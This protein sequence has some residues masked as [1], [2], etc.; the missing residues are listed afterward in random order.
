MSSISH[1]TTMA[2]SLYKSSY[3]AFFVALADV[4]QTY[5]VTNPILAPHARYYV[6][7]MRIKAYQQLLESYRSLTL[8]RMSRSFGVSEAFIDRDLSRFIASGRIACT[9]DKVSGV[10]TTDKLSSQNKTAIYEQFLKQGDLL[11]SG[12]LPRCFAR[13]DGQTCTNSTASLD[14]TCAGWT[15]DIVAEID[16]DARSLYILLS[17]VDCPMGAN[18]EILAGLKTRSCCFHHPQMAS[19]LKRARPPFP[20]G[21]SSLPI[22]ASNLTLANTLP[23]GQSFLWHRHA[24][25]ESGSEVTE[26]YSRAIDSPPRV[27]CLRQ[28]PTHIYYTVVPATLAATS[29]APDDTRLWLE[30]YFQLSQYPDLTQLYQAWEERDPALFGKTELNAKAVGVRVL[31]QD[32]WE[33]LIA[34]DIA[35]KLAADLCSFITST[36]NHITRIS[37]L[38]HK[39]CVKFSPAVLSLDNPDGQ[40]ETVYHLFPRAEQI[41]VDNLERVLRDLG[42]GYRAAFIAST[43][44]S[45][46]IVDNVDEELARW[47]AAPL[48]E[49]R[50]RLLELKGVGRKVADCVQLMCMDQVR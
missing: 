4:E 49:T 41:P 46:R 3:A 31:R 48:E 24:L 33:C 34:C 36:N 38:L 1:L 18:V 19:H 21:W 23:V 16:W 13:A 27:V 40:G 9:I 2:D 28:A 43:L 29:S 37:S 7:E 5:L 6:R 8:E 22:A 39:L 45:L 25:P 20:A 12:M 15:R 42:F 32:P 47:R 17:T 10:I 26:E 14:K 11:L 44:N 30:D 50:G 35:C